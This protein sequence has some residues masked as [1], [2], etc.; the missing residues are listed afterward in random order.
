[1]AKMPKVWTMHRAMQQQQQQQ[2][3]PVAVRC[4]RKWHWMHDIS[5][6]S[7][8]QD[9]LRWVRFNVLVL[10]VLDSL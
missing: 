1:M 10:L 9:E 5:N 3:T 6:N 8:I 4:S 7:N 2:S